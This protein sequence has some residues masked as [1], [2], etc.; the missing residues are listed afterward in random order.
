MSVIDCLTHYNRWRRGDLNELHLSPAI[1]GQAID[2]A[3]E[4]LTRL[5]RENAELRNAL[6][7]YADSA[8]WIREVRNTGPRI[9]WTKSLAAG[10]RGARARM[11]LMETVV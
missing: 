6:E 5:Q 4:D 9:T 2:A 10:D 1:I 7:W 11:A 3:V 8:H